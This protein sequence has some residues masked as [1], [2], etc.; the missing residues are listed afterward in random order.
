MWDYACACVVCIGCLCNVSTMM[1]RRTPFVFK[2]DD[3]EPPGHYERQIRR[4]R[5]VYMMFSPIDP[6]YCTHI[7]KYGMRMT[8]FV[9]RSDIA[10]VKQELRLV[11]WIHILPKKECLFRPLQIFSRRPS[12]LFIQIAERSTV[13]QTLKIHTSDPEILNLQLHR[14]FIFDL[15][16]ES[17]VSQ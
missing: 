2:H 15:T 13:L 17:L 10:R 1:M 5:N 3:C 12:R 9:V 8:I 4:A 16:T 7:G 14:P 11:P 6:Y